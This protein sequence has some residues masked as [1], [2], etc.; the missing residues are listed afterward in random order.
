MALPLTP[1][2][3]MIPKMRGTSQ[4]VRVTVWGPSS[5]SGPAV[6][7]TMSLLMNGKVVFRPSDGGVVII[8]LYKYTQKHDVKEELL[9]TT[10]F[11]QKWG[12][13]GDRERG[14][15]VKEREI[16]RKRE[17]GG[18]K[19]KGEKMGAGQHKTENDT[20]SSHTLLLR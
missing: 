18:E 14:G 10:I 12:K 5:S 8:A 7:E 4:L 6:P 2:T 16:K 19:E 1:T 11:Y 17:N 20:K 9:I 15:G 3:V 13:S